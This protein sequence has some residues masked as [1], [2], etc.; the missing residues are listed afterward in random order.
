MLD[1]FMSSRR[2]IIEKNDLVTSCQQM[3]CEVGANKACAACNK[4]FHRNHSNR[5]ASLTRQIPLVSLNACQLALNHEAI[6]AFNNQQKPIR[7]IL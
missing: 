2:E 5:R 7:I 3:V 6:K 4:C 1:V